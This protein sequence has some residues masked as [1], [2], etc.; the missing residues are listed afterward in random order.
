METTTNQNSLSERILYSLSQTDGLNS[1]QLA[2]E[3]EEDHQK[4]V[5]ALKSLQSL[6]SIIAVEQLSEA[7]LELTAEGICFGLKQ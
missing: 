6:G 1:L 3:Y 2:R 5:G 4:V 7:K